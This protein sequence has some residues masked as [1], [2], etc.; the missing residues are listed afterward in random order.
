VQLHSSIRFSEV[1]SLLEKSVLL[2][3]YNITIIN[4]FMRQWDEPSSQ[5]GKLEGIDPKLSD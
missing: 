2:Y 1:W 5:Y 4:G 3:L